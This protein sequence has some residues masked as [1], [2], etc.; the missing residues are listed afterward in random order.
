M[1]EEGEVRLVNMPL[2]VTHIMPVQKMY[3]AKL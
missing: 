3:M 1:G 2:I